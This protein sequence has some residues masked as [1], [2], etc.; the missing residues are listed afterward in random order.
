MKKFLSII[1]SL[2]LIFT[3]S[4]TVFAAEEEISTLQNT[5]S[6]TIN[7]YDIYVATRTSS[8]EV[9]TNNDISDETEEII[10]SDMIENWLTELSCLSTE[11]LTS[12]GYDNEQINLIQNYSGER[13][14]TNP[15]LRGIFAD[16]TAS[17]S[18]VSAST[19]SL[20]VKV[21]WKWSNA[22]VLSGSAIKD[23]PAIRWQGT[24]NAG[25][26]I[27]LALNKSGSSCSFKYYSRYTGEAEQ[28]QYTRTATVSSNDP[29]SHAYAYVPLGANSNAN[30]DYYAKTG[31]LTIKVDRT[32]TNSI[33]E[34]AFVFGYGHPIITVSPSLSLPASFGIGFSSGIEKMCEIAI[35]MT[36][37][38][39]ITSY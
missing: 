18:K 15:S 39:V 36:S 33:K 27:N 9:L 23:M 35:R 10:K 22:P 4:V 29:Y 34:A 11:E 8:P 19:S 25:Q 21:T 7:E 6:I 17:F 13:I 31:T 14:E 5:S 30:I 1:I 2:S 20:S 38:G 37:S 32:G 24:N 16:L 28:Y 26:P 12:M 3:M